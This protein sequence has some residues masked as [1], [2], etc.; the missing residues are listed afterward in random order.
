MAQ[1]DNIAEKKQRRAIFMTVVAIVGGLVAYFATSIYGQAWRYPTAFKWYETHVKTHPHSV[2]NTGKRINYSILQVATACT[3][4]PAQTMMEL[5]LIWPH[6]R[7]DCALFL[8]MSVTHFVRLNEQNAQQHVKTK[9]PYTQFGAIHWIGVGDDSPLY[10]ALLGDKGWA[11]GG[12]ATS[13]L[14]SRQQTLVDN[15]NSGKDQNPWY[16]LLPQPTDAAGRQAFLSMP[17]IRELFAQ[18]AVTGGA[19]NACEQ[20]FFTS[21]I[22]MLFSGGLCKVAQYE[23][24]SSKSAADIFNMYFATRVIVEQNCSGA[25]RAGALSSGV[26]AGV[27]GATMG[28]MMAGSLKVMV[29]VV[30]TGPLIALTVG[31]TLVTGLVTGIAGGLAGAAAAKE[32]CN[33]AL[34]LS[35]V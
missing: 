23:T 22:A 4:V 15:W 21:K 7:L 17:M 28:A 14:E 35:K 11:S 5:F 25:V 31:T 34:A 16:Y 33:Q 6:L 29:G 2:E 27:S 8:M 10:K 18:S 3:F 13:T 12:C 1:R 26:S 24:S 30:S 9:N 32:Q 20:T 19:E